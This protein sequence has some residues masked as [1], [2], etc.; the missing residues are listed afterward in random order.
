MIV[1][2]E[3]TR[4]PEDF[5]ELLR[6][7]RVTVLNQTPAAFQQLMRLP[8]LYDS[9]RGGLSL[10]VVIFGGEALDPQSLRP[11]IEHFGDTA[12]QLINM[13]GITE[14][15]VHVTYRPITRADLDTPRSPIGEHIADLG[16]RVLDADLNV[17]PV[18]VPGELYV[19]GAGLARGYLNRPGLTAERFIADPLSER[20]ERLYRTGDVARWNTTGELEYLGRAD[21]QVKI[22][23]YRI[24]LGEIA[25]ELRS[26]R[27]IAEAVVISH[28]GPSG[29]RLVAYLVG[30]E[31][32]ELDT[33]EIR[34][35]LSRALPD[36]MI[37]YA[38]V[39]LERL[40]LTAHGK[41]DRRALP[42]P[43]ALPAARFEAPQG[44]V[45][46][47]VA[48]IWRDVLGVERVG[49][50][51]NF[52]ELGG[53]SLVAL[54]V[55]ERM[56]SR[57]V[58]V[59][60]RTLF[61]HPRLAQFVH[62]LGR[63]Q[64]TDVV[65]PPNLIPPSCTHL[66]PPMLTLVQLSAA[67]IARIEAAVPGGAANIQDIYPLAPLQEGILFHHRLEERR[68]AYVTSHILSFEHRARL[69]AFIDSFN[70]VIARHD[71]L[72]TAV[73]WEDLREPVQVVYRT[74]PL[75]VRWW[76]EETPAGG[77]S[78]QPPAA[79]SSH[80]RLDVR[81]APLIHAWARRDDASDT[82]QLHLFTHHLVDD[83]T[84][85]KL[86]VA[87]IDLIQR[88]R[89]AQLPR[90]VPFRQ[91]VAQARLGVSAPEHEA[92]FKNLLGDV[93]EPTAPF[94]LADVQSDGTR[95]VEATRLLDADV[96][97]QV[98][99]E[100]RRYGVSAASLFHLAWA[101]VLSRTAG[102]DDVVF[103]TVLFGRMQAGEGA[104]RALGMFI[105]TLPLRIRLGTRTVEECLVQT[106]DV[107]TQLLHH[108]HASLALAQ[109]C[110]GVPR[111]TALF[112]ALL[113]YRHGFQ[114]SESSSQT[115]VLPGVRRIGGAA[116]NNFPFWM[117][118]DDLGAGFSVQANTDET[119]DAQWVC[120]AMCA[121]VESLVRALRSD[122]GQRVCEL[123]W[124]RD[125]EPLISPRRA[126]DPQSP[127]GSSPWERIEQAAE[128]APQ[129]LALVASEERLSYGELMRQ[130][131]RVAEQLRALGVTRESRVGVHGER[132]IAFVVGMLGVLKAGGVFVP[133]DAQLPTERLAYQLKDSA[134]QALLATGAVSWAGPIPV[135]ELTGLLAA[136]EAADR[137]A[138]PRPFPAIH[139][140]QAAY[141]IYTSGST[142]A[143]KG[144]IVSH[145]ALANYVQ[146]VLE[147]LALPDEVRSL[148]MVSTVAADLG[149]TVLFGAL[150]SG[151]TLHLISASCAFDP[152][153]FAEYLRAQRL[154][155]LKI[156]PSH[157]KAL[158]SAAE[159]Q[160]VLPRH[161]LILGG[162][163]TSWALLE[164]IRALKPECRVINHYG[165]TET[166]VGAL[167]QAAQDASRHAA[168]LP[169]GRP[170]PNTQAYVLDAFLNPV[171][172]GVAGELYVGGAGVARGYNGRGG[173][174]AERFVANPYAVGERLYR[175]GD[176]VK[177][178]TD[179]SVEF[180]GRLDNQVK[181]R[182]YRVELGEVAS[183]LIALPGV[184]QA[185]VIPHASE[186]GRTQLVAYVMP[187]AAGD[188]E[189]GALRAQL[190]ERLPEYMV[191][192]AIVVLEHWPLTPNGKLD[193]K[194]LPDPARLPR[195]MGAPRTA[196]ERALLPIW[197]RVLR[198]EAIGLDDNFFELG[199]DSILVLQ[200]VAE[201][202]KAGLAIAPKQLFERPT[203]AQLA[204]VATARAA[205]SVTPVRLPD[206]SPS[207]AQRAAIPIAA[208]EIEDVYPLSPMQQGLLLH[209]LVERGS[210]MYLIQDQYETQ[211]AID[212]GAFRRAWQAVVDRHP[213]LRTSFFWQSDGQP[214][215]VV[216]RSAEMPV[217]TVDWSDLPLSIAQ[218]R[219]GALLAQEVASG[220][221]MDRAPLMRLRLVKWPHGRYRIVESHHH[222]LIDAW[223]RSTLFLDFFDFY[224]AFSA[225]TAL[226]RVAPRPYRDFIAWLATQDQEA[227]RRYWRMR[228]PALKKSRRCR[229]VGRSRKAWPA[230]RAPR[231]YS[232]FSARS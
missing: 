86:A 166:T 94:G 27:E 207:A 92:F 67:E 138:Q 5:L 40:P 97:A 45:E 73:L 88:G 39:V 65:A 198:V 101:W 116:H 17:T 59:Q 46:E 225:G 64:R 72:R 105:N 173:L 87:E 144:V 31:G 152:D 84:T 189:A 212:E 95:M 42:E 181:I 76:E 33:V 120:T 146:G 124:K 21:S 71:I 108:E 185:E 132:S 191:P 211:M 56:R 113:N 60:V 57:G 199:G 192:N 69:E 78:T 6:Q 176:R 90:S 34:E 127:P 171:P 110:S 82:W 117:A 10:R 77:A 98:R 102:R 26:Q 74:A 158:L 61:E 217:E 163:A 141:V 137:E 11:W 231:T 134:A 147:E 229:F 139:P 32:A 186:D 150:C 206:V 99:R 58:P 20:G 38:L 133:L 14:T 62:A 85:V 174:T 145:G 175:T 96:A 194:A 29:P 221:A 195:A 149:H 216:R 162:E 93:I 15:T 128:R 228:S 179:G 188:V 136:S 7:Q 25:A 204:A 205:V 201:A 80:Y 48:S 89:H 66:E 202:R 230:R 3:V 70:E 184:R 55:L 50:Q 153:G 24:E 51:D 214:L 182:G 178:L 135:L 75:T 114:G 109:R 112:S 79:P 187:E 121:A 22:R 169:I 83:N 103:G 140:A 219:L 155:A 13:Y 35:R 151:R 209:T 156:V 18:G 123:E 9:A 193:R 208:A 119:V 129:A 159:P 53:H 168:T 54:T 197:Q 224:F 43:A 143:P 183:A 91:F 167:T 177:R 2:L 223:C 49:R 81:Q 148:A 172:R 23:G 180:L 126:R 190:A 227:A 47:T 222:I 106:H 36:Y 12:P 142:G 203:L 213:I 68:D 37:P 8:A 44:T 1:P 28:E 30:R 210:G 161:T 52:F 226:R 19:A 4:S 215:Q 122:P 170:L 220:F 165:P 41:L 200:I 100:A 218:E 160:D 104:D 125:E 157:L 154:D 118:V 63:G 130:V 16:V 232:S 131:A 107:L 196:F 164:R 115:E 111:G